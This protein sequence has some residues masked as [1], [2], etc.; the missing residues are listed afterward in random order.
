MDRQHLSQHDELLPSAW[1]AV[2]AGVSRQ[3]IHRLFVNGK[4]DGQMIYGRIYVPH[5]AVVRLMSERI[6]RNPRA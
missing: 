5:S 6:A 4:L 2:I 3:W 1:V